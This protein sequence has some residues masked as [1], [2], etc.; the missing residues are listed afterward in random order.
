MKTTVANAS[1]DRCPGLHSRRGVTLMELLVVIVII[2]ILLA[3][4]F[5]ALNAARES[6]RRSACQSNLRQ[7]GVGLLAR[8]GRSPDQRYCSGA[9]HW[10]YDGSVVD[11][12]WVADLMK[13]GTPAGKM[14]CPSNP[15]EISETYNDLLTMDPAAVAADACSCISLEDL[16]GSAEQTAP[17]GQVIEN[18]CRTI[19]EDAPGADVRQ[20]IVASQILEKH[21]NTNYTAS[22]LL[23]RGGVAL[24]ANGNPKTCSGCATAPTDLKARG[25]STGPLRQSTVDTGTAP[26]S[27]VPL[28]G[29]GAAAGILSQTVGPVELGVPVAK[30]FT[31]GPV[32]NPEMTLP[33]AFASGTPRGGASGWW[34]VWARG[35][36]QDYRGFAPVHRGTCNLLFAD[37]SVKTFEDQNEDG[38][39]NNGFTSTTSNGFADDTVEISP[40]DVFS[41]WSLKESL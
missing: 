4:L 38:V 6:S 28:L 36:L 18:P 34:A 33:V 2:S 32:L 29:C 40:N 39:L 30:S 37:G 19:V 21:F 24:D 11:Y 9:F 27:F 14:L 22:W 16:A 12:G 41:L 13:Q 35:T 7:L 10:R 23:V 25:S 15:A 1:H 17:D 20:Q 8:A 5:P 3:L 26:S 31:D